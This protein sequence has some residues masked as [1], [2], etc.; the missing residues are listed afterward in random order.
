MPKNGGVFAFTDNRIIFLRIDE[1]R[2]QVKAPIIVNMFPQNA[3]FSHIL[4]CIDNDL[5][6]IPVV[7]E[8]EDATLFVVWDVKINTEKSNFSIDTKDWR[9]GH[10]PASLAGYVYTEYLY[11]FNLDHGVKNFFFETN[12]DTRNH[13]WIGYTMNWVEDTA[14][15]HGDIQSKET[16]MECETIDGIERFHLNKDNISFDRI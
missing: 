3:R 6:T 15:Q 8:E 2:K 16:L 13:Q 11:Y 1:V 5:I 14:L 9:Y 12:W 10:G 7:S 4:P